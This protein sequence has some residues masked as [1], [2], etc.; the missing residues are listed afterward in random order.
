MVNHVQNGAR[1]P[2]SHV[3]LSTF[4]YAFAARAPMPLMSIFIIF[5]LRYLGRGRY[6]DIIRPLPQIKPPRRSV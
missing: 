1:L 5:F 4:R 3:L 2:A 6:D